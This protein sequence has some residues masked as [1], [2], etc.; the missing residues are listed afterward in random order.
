MPG[1][2]RQ[3]RGIVYHSSLSINDAVL[4]LVWSRPLA[5]VYYALYGLK[6]T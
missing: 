2:E 5:C 6:E 4:S 3:G 1:L